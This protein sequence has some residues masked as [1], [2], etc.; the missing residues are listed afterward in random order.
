MLN[1]QPSHY[2]VEEHIRQLKQQGKDTSKLEA[3]ITM[4]LLTQIELESS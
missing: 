2:D 4:V 3:Y 1:E